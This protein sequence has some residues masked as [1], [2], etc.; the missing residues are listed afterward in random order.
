MPGR[1]AEEVFLER[2]RSIPHGDQGNVARRAGINSETF[3]K[4]R[5]GKIRPNPTLETLVGLAAAMRCPIA[6]LISDGVYEPPFDPATVEKLLRA[7]DEGEQAG[8]RLRDAV[9]AALRKP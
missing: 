7:A 8:K 3:S 2:I 6:Y 1:S 4:W 9:R 5:T